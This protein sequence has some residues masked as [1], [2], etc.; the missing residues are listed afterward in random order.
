MGRLLLLA[1]GLIVY[2]S[3]YPW[4]FH[5]EPSADPFRILFH[6]WPH[7]WDRYLLRDAFLNIVI[8]APVGGLAFLWLERR[9][10][11][12][13][14]LAAGVALGAALSAA[15]ELLQVYVPGRDTSLADVLCNT[16]GAL[17]GAILAAAFAPALEEAMGKR[18]HRP[19]GSAVL[20]L[21]LWAC[22]QLYPFIPVLSRTRLRL[23]FDA[24]FTAAAFSPAETWAVAAEWFAVALALET[25]CGRLRT[26]WLAAAMLC[27]PLRALIVT[28]TVHTEEVCGALLALIL[29]SVLRD[30]VRPGFALA[31]M[32]SA[33]LLREVA[34]LHLSPSPAP[35]SWVPF[36]AT[37]VSPRETGFIVICRK[38]FDYGALLWLGRRA[39]VSYGMGAAVLAPALF[40]L[41]WLQ[42]YLPGRTPEITDAVLALIMALALWLSDIRLRRGLR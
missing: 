1:V 19:A 18:V 2:G 36:A 8:Y 37:L 24:V 14:A 10:S 40:V 27:L 22:A 23:A 4:R 6:S 29:Y 34:P 39:A 25:L 12:A 31:L 30:R 38:L 13:L 42:R 41:E 35:F 32:A 5:F 9:H 11:R 21:G 16:A 17:A 7:V 20:L 26:S 33:I 3:L 28:R 15:M